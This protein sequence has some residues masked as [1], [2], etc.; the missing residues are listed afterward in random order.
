MEVETL[1]R[2]AKIRVMEKLIDAG[3]DDEKK[4]Q[5]F[6]LADIV[7]AKIDNKEIPMLIEFREAVKNHKVVSYFAG[8]TR[9]KKEDDVGGKENEWRL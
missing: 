5:N 9:K 8:E 3:F 6:E 7:V 4:I 2:K 1:D